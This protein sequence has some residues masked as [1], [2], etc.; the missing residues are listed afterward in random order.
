M[1]LFKNS[2]AQKDQFSFICSALNFQP[3][4]SVHPN[5]SRSSHST[6]IPGNEL[7]ANENGF[8]I[9]LIYKYTLTLTLT[10][11]NVHEHRHADTLTSIHTPFVMIASIS[12]SF[13]SSTF[14]SV[15][16]WS[17]AITFC[18]SFDNETLQFFMI[19]QQK[20]NNS[21]S[22]KLVFFN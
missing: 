3:L 2:L 19:Q 8:H 16:D 5:K 1:R 15:L 14:N 11:T 12:L 20:K 13:A 7:N 22:S 17:F 9:S 4:L 10:Q 6:L 21:K 18:F